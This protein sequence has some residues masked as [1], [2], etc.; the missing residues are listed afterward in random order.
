MSRLPR[1]FGLHMADDVE[2]IPAKQIATRRR[3]G[4]L[5]DRPVYEYGLIGGLYLITALRKEGRPEILSSG[6]H[7]AIA[8]HVARKFAPTVEFTE[9][10]KS[11]DVDI[12]DLEPFLAKYEALTE[13]LRKL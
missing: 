10:A 5:G 2:T 12:R 6:S 13:E 7:P 4:H 3:I 1:I 11:E 8:R 9:L